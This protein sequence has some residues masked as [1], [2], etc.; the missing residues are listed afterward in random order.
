MDKKQF[1]RKKCIFHACAQSISEETKWGT[2]GGVEERPMEEICF[3]NCF[4]NMH[5][6]LWQPKSTFPW[7]SSF[8]IHLSLT[9]TSNIDQKNVSHT[10]SQFSLMT[11]VYQLKSLPRWCQIQPFEHIVTETWRNL[12][13]SFYANWIR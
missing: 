2:K 5:G 8:T 1:G 10:C 9:P 3:Q 13:F 11:T 12:L 4:S 6:L 7:V